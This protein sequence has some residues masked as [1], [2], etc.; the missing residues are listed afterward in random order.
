M[1]IYVTVWISITVPAGVQNEHLT[2]DNPKVVKVL[3]EVELEL[4]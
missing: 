3:L 1:Y 2:M 4:E